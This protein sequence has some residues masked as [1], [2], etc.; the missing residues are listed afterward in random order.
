MIATT[1]ATVYRGDG[2][3][4]YADPTDDDV[5]VEGLESIPMAITELSRTVFDVETDQA[6]TIRYGIGRARA[7]LDIRADDRIHDERVDRW[8]A[9]RSVSG[10]GATF[11]GARTLS[12]DLRAV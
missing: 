4:E 9:V 12:L 1:V 3:D 6:R 2:A 7:G 8:W 11:F 10:G 5:P